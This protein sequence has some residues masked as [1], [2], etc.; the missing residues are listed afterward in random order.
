MCGIAGW[1]NC[2]YG[3]SIL[4]KMLDAI[5]HRGPDERNVYHSKNC[6]IGHVRLSILDLSGGHQPYKCPQGEILAFNGEIYNFRQLDEEL[7]A[8]GFPGNADG[9]TAVLSRAWSR[10]GIN[11]LVKFDGMFAISVY[12]PAKNALFLARDYYGEKPLF[13]M[14]K[15]RGIVFASEIK[16]FKKLP[17]WEPKLAPEGIRSF[18]STRYIAGSN[19][20]ISDIKRLLPKEYIVVDDSGIRKGKWFKGC[21]NSSLPETLNEL[22][23]FFFNSINSRMVSD[24]PLGVYLS[25]G[26]DS[27]IIASIA[28]QNS[29]KNVEAYT[30]ALDEDDE[31]FQGA[32][33][34]AREIGL[35]HKPFLLKKDDYQNLPRIVRHMDLPK[36]DSIVVA[37]Y[38]LAE[39]AS[40]SLKVVL[41]GDGADEIDFGY[42]HIHQIFKLQMLFK[43]FPDLLAKHS[44]KILD[45]M[46]SKLIDVF[47]PYSFSVGNNGQNR[48]KE[49]L[50]VSTKTG[51]LYRYLTGLFVGSEYNRLLSSACRE[52]V[53][54]SAYYDLPVVYLNKEK[55]KSKSQLLGGL[56][57]K[58]WLPDCLL[59]K[60]DILCMAHSLENR[61]PFLNPSFAKALENIRKM[62]KTSIE[63]KGVIRKVA[64]KYISIRLRCKQKRPF[65]LLPEQRFKDVWEGFVE[66][67]LNIK[68]IRR[69][70]LWNPIEVKRIIN[71]WRNGEVLACKHL[72]ALIIFEL[73]LECWF[74]S[75]EL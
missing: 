14:E 49:M 73:W 55:S 32:L 74:P 28:A 64:E 31:D 75:F 41:T 67:Y 12:D 11:G 59:Y 71:D 72:T 33:E 19:F 25:G 58:E 62:E 69:R 18:L 70:G 35:N 43:Y 48:I 22:E 44:H 53:I 68:L 51:M 63:N 40:Q 17:D 23:Q 60:Q 10:W 1:F 2:N 8:L 20:P 52:W 61:A 45:F 4:D 13:F 66:D 30:V 50:G 24:V 7:S 29:T 9:D 3:P 6:S 5:E 65:F 54:D 42:H 26:L 27:G 34:T 37:Q 38:R 36:A 57:L 15:G 16:A 46:P 47:S 56:E 39:T 21:Y